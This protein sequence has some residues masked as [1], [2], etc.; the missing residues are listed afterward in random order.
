MASRSPCGGAD[1]VS[2]GEDYTLGWA[3]LTRLMIEVISKTHDANLT[4]IIITAS[5]LLLAFAE[6]VMRYGSVKFPIAE[7]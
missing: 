7:G 3:A 4:V 2:A 5:I 1:T 6:L